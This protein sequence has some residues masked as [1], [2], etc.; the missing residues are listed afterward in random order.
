VLVAW[1]PSTRRVTARRPSRFS[2]PINWCTA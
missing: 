2:M 1:A